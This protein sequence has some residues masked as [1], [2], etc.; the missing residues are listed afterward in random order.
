M[1]IGVLFLSQGIKLRFIVMLNAVNYDGGASYEDVK[2]GL[3][4]VR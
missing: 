4:P 1:T 2:S 3:Q